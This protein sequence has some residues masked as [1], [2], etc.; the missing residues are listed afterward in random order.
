[1]INLIKKDI[2]IQKKM[3]PLV[4]IFVIIFAL[5][6]QVNSRGSIY[7]LG[8]TIG[9]ILTI[10]ALAYDETYKGHILINSL[11][12]T[13]KNVV[14]SKYLS[15][16]FFTAFS[17][18][19][20]TF[21][22]LIFNFIGISGLSIKYISF[23][24]IKTITATVIIL[25]SIMIPLFLKFGTKL[26]KLF[27]FIIFFMFFSISNFIMQNKDETLIKDILNFIIN[28]NGVNLTIISIII[29]T[30]IYILSMY[31]SFKIYANKD[32]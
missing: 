17:L 10:G 6:S 11:P 1:M 32:F 2:L 3:L 13:R 30:C 4:C 31:F 14:I 22:A 28:N 7:I 20:L 8:V 29:L 19:F 15:I 23:A 27:N 21:I 25:S 5:N 12:L 18:I 24:D 16:F 26:G 9:Y